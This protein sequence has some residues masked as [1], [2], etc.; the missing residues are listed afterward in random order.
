MV[1][2][3]FLEVWFIFLDFILCVFSWSIHRL[4]KGNRGQ[5]IDYVNLRNMTLEDKTEF[6]FQFALSKGHSFAVQILS[7]LGFLAVSRKDW[8]TFLAS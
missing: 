5:D 2:Y 6:I 3:V 8:T 7:L 1:D 4:T